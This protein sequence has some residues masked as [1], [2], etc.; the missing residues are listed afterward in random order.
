MV[1]TI[2]TY[3]RNV[4]AEPLVEGMVHNNTIINAVGS[5]EDIYIGDAKHVEVLIKLGTMTNTATIQYHINAMENNSDTI[6]RTFD[7][8]I[9]S[10][11]NATDYITVDGFTLSDRINIT[12]TGILNENNFFSGVYCK[13]I[14]KR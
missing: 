9:L 10:A 14:V 7:G 12:W 1:D 4:V 5:S 6:I 8:T 3:T 2:V 11:T 13:V